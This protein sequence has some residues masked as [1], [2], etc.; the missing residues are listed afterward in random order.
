MIFLYKINKQHS[1]KIIRELEELH[2]QGLHLNR[3]KSVIIRDNKEIK[4]DLCHISK[5]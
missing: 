5:I 4:R 3:N 2:V 1:E